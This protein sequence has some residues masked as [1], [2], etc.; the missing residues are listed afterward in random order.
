[1]LKLLLRSLQKCKQMLVAMSE[2]LDYAYTFEQL[3]LYH[4]FLPMSK[5]KLLPTGLAFAYKRL[6]V[7]YAYGP[8]CGEDLCLDSRTFLV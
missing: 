5:L 4:T 2:R 6:L 8:L 3:L 1:M 7:F